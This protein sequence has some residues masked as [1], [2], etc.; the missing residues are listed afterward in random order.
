VATYSATYAANWTCT[1][2]GANGCYKNRVSYSASTFRAAPPD[3][4][5]PAATLYT[6]GYVASWNTGQ[7]S[8]CSATACNTSGWYTRSVWPASWKPDEPDAPRP[9]DA[10]GCSVTCSYT[11]YDYGLYETW[12]E[13]YDAGWEFCD[14]RYRDD[15]QGGLLTCRHGYN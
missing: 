14:T 8:G 15:G 1:A 12:R 2:G 5:V 6:Y 9:P 7:W 4:P 13:C 10:L 11:C 3:A